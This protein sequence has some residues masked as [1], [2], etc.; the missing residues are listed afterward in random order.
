MPERSLPAVDVVE[1]A[2]EF[3]DRPLERG[4]DGIPVALVLELSPS[5]DLHHEAQ[6][7]LARRQPRRV[8][9]TSKWMPHAASKPRR[10]GVV[11]RASYQDPGAAVPRVCCAGSDASSRPSI[12]CV[13]PRGVTISGQRASRTSRPLTPPSSTARSG[14]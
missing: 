12:G 14:P 5:E 11:I 7:V 4:R 8:G 9:C 6:L 3:G 13:T 1:L 10:S 2:A